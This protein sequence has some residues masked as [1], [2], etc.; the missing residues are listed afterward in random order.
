MNLV[1]EVN[2]PS[3]D[4][5]LIMDIL[6]E[7]GHKFV[8]FETDGINR[9]VLFRQTKNRF[10]TIGVDVNIA[11][12]VLK[13]IALDLSRN[14]SMRVYSQEDG[15]I[16]MNH[17]RKL[18]GSDT[19]CTFSRIIFG[20]NC[21]RIDV[22]SQNLT[23]D[24]SVI[25]EVNRLIVFN[26]RATS[27]VQI[28]CHEE[29]KSLVSFETDRAL[30]ASLSFFD[31]D[32]DVLD[33]TTEDEVEK[34]LSRSTFLSLVSKSENFSYGDGG[35]SAAVLYRKIKLRETRNND[36]FLDLGE[37]WVEFDALSIIEILEKL[38]FIKG[39]ASPSSSSMPLDLPTE[40]L[41]GEESIG[42]ELTVL[43]TQSHDI[44]YKISQVQ[45]LFTSK[46]EN[47]CM[48]KFDKF[49][50]MFTHSRQ[51]D[52]RG[53]IGSLRLLDL[54]F[55]AR[56]YRDVIWNDESSSDVATFILTTQKSEDINILSTIIRL[57]SLRV[58]FFYRFILQAIDYINSQVVYP[59]Q[60]FL[61]DE[62]T[63][64][65]VQST[66]TEN[67]AKVEVILITS[68]LSVIVPR[69]SQSSDLLGLTVQ[70]ALTRI[71]PS[72]KLVSAPREDEISNQS[73]SVL[74]FDGDKNEWILVDRMEDCR[75][76]KSLDKLFEIV[77]LNMG[78]LY[79]KSNDYYDALK[80]V[81]A[82]NRVTSNFAGSVLRIAVMLREV[83][84]FS[85]ISPLSARFDEHVL[86]MRQIVLSEE[87]E[88][89][90][91]SSIRHHGGITKWENDKAQLWHQITRQL[92]NLDVIVDVSEREMKLL[93]CDVLNSRTLDLAV[94]QA[95]FYLLLG[96]WFDNFHE[97][98][99]PNED[100]FTDL[101]DLTFPTASKH[102]DLKVDRYG[103]SQYFSYYMDREMTFELLVVQSKIQLSLAI[104]DGIFSRSIPSYEYLRRYGSLDRGSLN[105]EH[106]LFSLF[107]I[108]S[109]QTSNGRQH[110]AVYPV[111]QIELQSLIVQVLADNDVSQIGVTASSARVIDGRIG[112]EMITGAKSTLLSVGNSQHL[113]GKFG[114][115]NFPRFFDGEEDSDVKDGTQM[116]LSVGI[117]MSSYLNWMN[118]NLYLDSAD[119]FVSHL[120]ITLLLAEYF[121][122]FFRF[123]EFGSP[124]LATYCRL[125]SSLLP[126]GG[127]DFRLL[128]HKPHVALLNYD[129][130]TYLFAEVDNG[131]NYRY[132]YDTKGSVKTS[133]DLQSLSL[134][135]VKE[136]ETYLS[137]RGARG[138][139]GFGSAKTLLEFMN[140][141]I[142][143]LHQSERN[144]QDFK[145]EITCAELL[146]NLN[147]FKMDEEVAGLDIIIP[148]TNFLNSLITLS[149]NFPL[150]SS[151]IVI[152]FEDVSMIWKTI[153]KF[154]DLENDSSEAKADEP[155]YLQRFS[156]V[157]C[158]AKLAG[159]RLLLIDNTLGM[160]L[161]FF[162]VFIF[163]F[164]LYLFASNLSLGFPSRICNRIP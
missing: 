66:P 110:W 119:L 27:L 75:F 20:V 123:E 122:C 24:H 126:Y 26:N 144:T 68:D 59:I 108:S 87:L 37:V 137:Y 40:N 2:T 64:S 69:N 79:D 73:G 115:I 114:L 106:P 89:P 62:Q 118:I 22:T 146:R 4:R 25:L 39:Q 96:F 15:G 7:F 98:S 127:T 90:L 9:A 164:F 101:N 47:F 112:S 82:V 49:Q 76:T 93:F 21:V 10:K 16:F 31:Q 14:S 141:F 99:E 12:T 77:E 8:K 138:S 13:E 55:Y 42:P 139:S 142:Y 102:E 41:L 17:A 34:P 132:C 143:Q 107:D 134:V 145:V 116:P 38:S 97:T 74:S 103:D 60:N 150:D 50:G 117:L 52:F 65:S 130:Q 161:P 163:F 84:I 67:G 81:L 129:S 57:H 72:S 124:S 71:A 86:P 30:N 6:K 105:F 109:N 121:S 151:D 51:N 148:E 153:S 36:W 1:D 149:K 53:S 125:N 33:S 94:T 120:D 45:L 128:L 131:A 136:F 113:E 100:E 3:D 152:S 23:Y 18:A 83:H 158:F 91:F 157:N 80:G 46:Q 58:C 147:N 135:L 19:V 104:D 156:Q 92:A 48:L 88:A 159:V 35:Y 63:T 85:S 56:Q 70:N 111:G 43:L 54:T 29:Y 44:S 160:H 154:L 61:R 5:A 95:E 133:Y 140:L 155:T 32:F 11:S 28:G 162:Q 78:N